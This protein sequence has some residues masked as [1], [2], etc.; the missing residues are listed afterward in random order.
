MEIK[1]F[2]SKARRCVSAELGDLKPNSLHIFALVGEN[3]FYLCKL[4]YN[5]VL[6]V[7][8]VLCLSYYLNYTIYL[9]SIID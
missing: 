4:E 3:L 8:E 9:Y 7:V 5:Q 6:F 1:P 2:F